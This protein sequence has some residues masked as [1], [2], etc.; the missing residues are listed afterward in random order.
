[1]R[2]NNPDNISQLERDLEQRFGLQDERKKFI[3][4][5]ML[6]MQGLSKSHVIIQ[7]YPAC[8]SAAWQLG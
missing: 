2:S 5:L 6:Q 7:S 8:D 4:D 3:K 1:M